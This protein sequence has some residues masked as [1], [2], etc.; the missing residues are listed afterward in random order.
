VASILAQD[1][2]TKASVELARSAYQP[3]ATV[4]RLRKTCSALIV[5]MR[6]KAIERISSK[7]ATLSW[8]AGQACSS[9]EIY[10]SVISTV[11]CTSAKRSATRKRHEHRIAQDR[12]TLLH[13]AR[14]GRPHWRRSQTGSERR[15]R[16]TSRAAH[17]PAGKHFHAV[18]H[19]SKSAILEIVATASRVSSSSADV[20]ALLPNRSAIKA[21]LSRLSACVFAGCR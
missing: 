20:V 5:E 17:S 11:G 6:R 8:K 2:V 18:I 14:A 15:V 19:A 7:V 1:P 16:T 12:Q 21:R 13:I 10:A 9:A 4:D 3:S